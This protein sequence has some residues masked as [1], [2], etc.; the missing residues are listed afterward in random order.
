MEACLPQMFCFIEHF[1][2]LKEEEKNSTGNETFTADNKAEKP[3]A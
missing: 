3:A 1:T 2:E